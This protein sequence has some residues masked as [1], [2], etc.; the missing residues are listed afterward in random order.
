MPLQDL[1]HLKYG[2]RRGQGPSCGEL[3]RSFACIHDAACLN[4]HA[5]SPSE[6]A[7]TTAAL[8]PSEAVRVERRPTWTWCQD[9][10]HAPLPCLLYH[11]YPVIYTCMFI[12]FHP[13]SLY[14]RTWSAACFSAAASL[15]RSPFDKL[16]RYTAQGPCCTV[17]KR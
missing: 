9:V 7:W 4:K 3:W 11:Y 16:W 2:V 12:I 17:H 1:A 5:A 15:A 6:G 14:L 10:A 8:R 13:L